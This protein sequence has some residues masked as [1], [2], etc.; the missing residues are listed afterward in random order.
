MRTATRKAIATLTALAAGGATWT[1]GSVGGARASEEVAETR[2]SFFIRDVKQAVSDVPPKGTSQGDGFF[3][4]GAIFDREGGKRIGRFGGMGC[5]T[6]DAA[7]GV[8]ADSSCQVDYLLP[9]GIVHTQIFGSTA[10][11][12]GGK[13]FPFGITGGTGAYRAARGEGTIAIPTDVKDQSDA[14]VRLTIRR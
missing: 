10:E 12:F 1:L 7:G 6:L 13:P 14:F 4:H 9:D 3:Y 5:I 2:L 11:L 8:P